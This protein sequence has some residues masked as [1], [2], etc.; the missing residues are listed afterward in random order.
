MKTNIDVRNVVFTVEYAVNGGQGLYTDA[1]SD[2]I[3]IES[4]KLED[5][6]V[7]LYD[8]IADD[9]LDT[10]FEKTIDAHVESRKA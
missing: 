10:I 9:V 1:Y 8:V 7:E 4:I 6:D 3:E 5:S 2:D